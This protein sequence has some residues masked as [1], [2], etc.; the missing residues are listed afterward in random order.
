MDVTIGNASFHKIHYP[1]SIPSTVQA[2]TGSACRSVYIPMS[3][4]KY[5]SAPSVFPSAIHVT[6]Y[7]KPIFNFILLNRIGNVFRTSASAIALQPT[8][9]PAQ[10]PYTYNS[11]CPN[12]TCRRGN[13][14][15]RFPK[16]PPSTIAFSYQNTSGAVRLFPTIRGT[17]PNM[18]RNANV[19]AATALPDASPINPSSKCLLHINASSSPFCR[20]DKGIINVLFVLAH[21]YLN[22]RRIMCDLFLSKMIKE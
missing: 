16:I 18:I 1:Y 4:K 8:K 10:I 14:D 6:A 15:A 11:R 9:I 2:S 17:T 7:I 20:L 12:G 22:R 5:Q 21:F 13:T 3:R 19:P